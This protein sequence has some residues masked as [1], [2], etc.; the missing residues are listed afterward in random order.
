VDA[1]RRRASFNV[2]HLAT[3]LKVDVFVFAHDEL[4][5]EEMSRRV[6]VPLRGLAVWFASPEDI[7]L[8]KLDWYRKGEGVSERQWRD[9]VGVIE[10]QGAAFDVGYVRRWADRLGLTESFEKALGEANRVE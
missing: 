7:V 8:Q 6:S 10:V 2:I 4:G 1:I 3:M 9:L 5:V